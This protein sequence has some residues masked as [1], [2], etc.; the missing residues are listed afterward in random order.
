LS[1]DVG[2]LPP[3][4]GLFLLS[5]TFSSILFFLCQ[6]FAATPVSLSSDDLRNSLVRIFLL[7]F[8]SVSWSGLPF[9]DCFLFDVVDCFL[10]LFAKDLVSA[11]FRLVFFSQVIGSPPS[12]VS[13]LDVDPTSSPALFAAIKVRL[14]FLTQT[15][16]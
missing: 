7:F 11:V 3:P 4:L 8:P 9:W 12:G 2:L 10:A 13:P 5:S 16:M 14:L 15:Q 1:P 6:N